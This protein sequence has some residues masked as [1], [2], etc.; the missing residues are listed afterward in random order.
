MPHRATGC[1]AE[2]RESLGAYVLGVLDVAEAAALRAH[3]VGCGACQA[4]RRELAAVAYLLSAAVPDLAA[5]RS[6]REE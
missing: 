3:L 1:A 2:H 4:E 5:A 6:L